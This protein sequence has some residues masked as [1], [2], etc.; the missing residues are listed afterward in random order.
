MNQRAIVR[1]LT[2][3]VVFGVIV[4]VP[5]QIVYSLFFTHGNGPPAWVSSLGFSAYAVAVG[6]LFI[7]FALF[8]RSRLSPP[9]LD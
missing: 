5:T 9:P 7:L 4:W 8:V 2:W 6:S 1:V 3:A